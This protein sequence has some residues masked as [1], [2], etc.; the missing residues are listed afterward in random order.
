MRA[1]QENLTEKAERLA[2]ELRDAQGQIASCRHQ[3]G[4]PYAATRETRVPVYDH[5]EVHGSD[6]WPVFR[7]VTSTEHGWE[8]RCTLCGT[9]EYTARTSPVISGYKPDFS[10]KEGKTTL[11]RG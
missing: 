10:A 2:R 1:E 6:S 9:I 8:Q 7:W 4:E 5:L 11:L 3:Y